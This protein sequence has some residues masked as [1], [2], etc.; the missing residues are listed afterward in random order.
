M[1]QEIIYG[2]E[3]RRRWTDDIKRSILAEVG[4]GGAT[5][6]SVAERHEIS[7]QH[8]YQ[9]RRE[10]RLREPEGGDEAGFVSVEVA[11][12]AKVRQTDSDGLEIILANH[13]RLRGFERL[14]A[15]ALVQLIRLVEQA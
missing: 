9:W 12:S 4:V 13:R 2:V 10:L 7:R 6:A 3:R 14:P 8:I 11:P 5:V 15:E 1:R